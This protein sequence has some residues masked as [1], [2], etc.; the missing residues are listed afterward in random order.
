MAFKDLRE[1]I[2]ELESRGLLR[3]IKTEVD[4]ELEITEITDRVSKME[5][6]KNVAL[7]F[8][9]VKG[10]D[11]P[12]LMNAFGS[13]ERMSIALGVESLDEIADDLRD[14][15]RL[16]KISL[17]NKMD[18]VTLIPKMRKAVNFP[19]YVKKA[20]CQEVVEMDNPSLD[21]LPILKCWPEDGGP[22]ITLPLVFTKNPETGKRNVGMY[23]LQKYDKNTTGMHWHIH[24]NGA[25][26]FRAAKEQGK[27][28][29]E[30][31]VAIGTDPVL[32][33][34]ATAPL[35]RDIDEMV[36]AGF[37]RHKS[38]EAN[39]GGIPNI[40]DV[41]MAVS[42]KVMR[43]GKAME[44]AGKSVQA[45]RLIAGPNLK[46]SRVPLPVAKAWTRVRDVPAPPAQSFRQWWKAREEEE[47]GR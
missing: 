11:M 18:L 46:I 22:F 17:A 47:G 37:L 2:E 9:N 26:N 38:V 6:E 36:F 35:P 28:R 44:A 40:W 3:R 19:K 25:E 20:P 16:P 23:R 34:A 32:T 24:K 45:G 42:S 31:A 43:S 30:V 14:F 39:R 5:G 29:I 27:D 1:F 41:G 4:A 8:E 10:Y 21:I 7:L 12:V 13:M 33:Y 15:M